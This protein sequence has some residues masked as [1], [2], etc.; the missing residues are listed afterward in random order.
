[1]AL[2]AEEAASVVAVAITLVVEVEG[3]AVV[4]MV[5]LSSLKHFLLLRHIAGGGGGGYDQGRS[6]GGSK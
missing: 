5:G 2:A 1:M 3:M 4:A 6:G